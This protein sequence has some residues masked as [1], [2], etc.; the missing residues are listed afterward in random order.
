MVVKALGA[1]LELL[2]NQFLS[3]ECDTLFQE[4]VTSTY[5]RA[6]HCLLVASMNQHS[7]NLT[8]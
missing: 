6:L 3:L 4:N 1:S 2:Q 7:I 5:V 8:K